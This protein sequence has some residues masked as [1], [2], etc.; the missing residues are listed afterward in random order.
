MFFL[1]IFFYNNNFF[2]IIFPKFLYNKG[3][4]FYRLETSHKLSSYFAYCEQVK[5]FLLTLNKSIGY[6]AKFEQVK[7]LVVIL[8]TLNT[9]KT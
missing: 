2:K 6:F 4:L 3:W 1:I 7:I 5:N 9:S 8:L